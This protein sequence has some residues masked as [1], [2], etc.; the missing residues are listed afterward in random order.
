MDSSQP[1]GAVADRQFK[2]M[3]RRVSYTGRTATASSPPEAVQA[4][5]ARTDTMPTN[6]KRSAD[7]EIDG[8]RY[9]SRNGGRAV[10]QQVQQLGEVAP[11]STNVGEERP[12]RNM[13][14]G[15]R[16]M[17]SQQQ[18][19]NQP[20]RSQPTQQI[21][22]AEN[23]MSLTG[24][25]FN[26]IP[27]AQPEQVSRTPATP[28]DGQ[29]SASTFKFDLSHLSET[30]TIRGPSLTSPPIV[31]P[32]EPL[33]RKGSRSQL[34]QDSLSSRPIQLSSSASEIFSIPP[35]PETRFVP[36]SQ[37]PGG[38][39]IPAQQPDLQNG[40]LV[41]GDAS[42]PP[43]EGAS[44]NN[45]IEGRKIIPL[46]RK[47]S[48]SQL[49]QPTPTPPSLP[50][51]LPSDTPAAFEAELERRQKDDDGFAAIK[52]P[53]LEPME[54]SSPSLS[55]ATSKPTSSPL[56]DKTVSILNLN[57]LDSAKASAASEPEHG[58]EDYVL[59]STTSDGSQNN[60]QQQADSQARQ[61]SPIGS[62]TLAPLPKRS[63]SSTGS[64]DQSSAETQATTPIAAIP[65]SQGV[66]F[67]TISTEDFDK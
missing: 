46:R 30:T 8:E 61:A 33:R 36:T 9:G 41:N 14:R 64:S 2:R 40:E 37:A 34:R 1:A 63:R 13:P 19:Q 49:S 10:S 5:V 28:S 57:M 59:K 26:Q 60:G 24:R 67:G 18:S 11:S 45:I 20:V 42:Q 44:S 43:I 55:T 16:R 7:T 4:T 58:T 31:K 62:R 56:D 65:T 39:N 47:S 3:P 53:T 17:D 25:T 21:F 50:I 12:I 54:L 66:Q 48:R 29:S 23:P 32:R 52:S 15:A 22:Q 27:S 35:A 38:E 6:G 51:Q